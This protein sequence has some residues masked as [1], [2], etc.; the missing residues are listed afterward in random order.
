[1]FPTWPSKTEL[2]QGRI[3]VGRTPKAPS[4]GEA[5][6]KLV[7]RSLGGI[8]G[9]W[10]VFWGFGGVFWGFFDLIFGFSRGRF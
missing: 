8:L 7:V 6:A 9:V 10:G 1:M 4:G 3:K 5:Y 2:R